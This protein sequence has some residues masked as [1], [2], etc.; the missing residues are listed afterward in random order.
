[1]TEWAKLLL[2][3]ERHAGSWPTVRLAA[4]ARAR[5]VR[6]GAGQGLGRPAR[7][8]PL[9]LRPGRQHLRRRQILLGA[10]RKL[11]RRRRAGG[12]TGEEGYWTW[13]DKIWDYSWQHFVDHEHGA[14]YRILTPDNQQISDE[15][16]PAG[17][18]DYHTMGACYEVLNVLKVPHER[19]LSL[20]FVRPARR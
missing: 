6:H 5:A 8:H 9:R 18:V 17:K 19:P 11:G 12:R 2:L 4:A 10:G 7:R 15:K 14:W 20:S 16:S 1:L 13:Y 3:L